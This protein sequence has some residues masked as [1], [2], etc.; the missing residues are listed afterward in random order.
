[1]RLGDDGSSLA[2]ITA[3]VEIMLEMGIL[4]AD[5]DNRVY[6]PENPPKVNLEDSAILK[7]IKS[8]L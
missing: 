6:V 7:K 1:V 3:V 8:Y 2:A 4:A 5:G